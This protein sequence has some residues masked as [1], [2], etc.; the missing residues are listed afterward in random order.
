MTD[1]NTIYYII[2]EDSIYKDKGF[3]KTSYGKH[4][5]IY[6]PYFEYNYCLGYSAFET[7]EEAIKKIIKNKE[8]RLNY[9]AKEFVKEKSELEKFLD[10]NVEVIDCVKEKGE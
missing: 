7:L 1:L 8:K 10:G 2:D 4:E 5:L 3:K 9:L 6:Q